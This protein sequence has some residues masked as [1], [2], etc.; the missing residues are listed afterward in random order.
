MTVVVGAQILVQL[1]LVIDL[2]FH[3]NREADFIP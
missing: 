1:D 2:K 3:Q